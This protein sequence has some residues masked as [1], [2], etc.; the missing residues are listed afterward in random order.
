MKTGSVE[1]GYNRKGTAIEFYVSDTGIG[2]PPEQ[3]SKIFQNFYQIESSI[4]RQYEGMGLGLAICKAYTE[5]L[6]GKIWLISEIGKGTTFYLTIPYCNPE[7]DQILQ[8]ASHKP[9][10]I[11]ITGYL[12]ILVADDDDLNFKLLER[13]FSSSDIKLIR[14]VN[15]KEAVGMC[16]LHKAIDLVL[17][18]I[19]MPEMDGY[20][21]TSIIR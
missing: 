15:G 6:G 3:H 11:A 13:I 2:I 19:R 1:F 8:P 7:S 5:L 16:M 9:A 10:D 18:D 12:T 20:S 21:A 17:M 4:S 14:A